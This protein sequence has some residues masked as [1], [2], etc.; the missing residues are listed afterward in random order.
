MIRESPYTVGELRRALE[1]FDDDD[2]ALVPGTDV[3]EW[4]PIFT[5][6]SEVVDFPEGE[7]GANEL[8]RRR[9]KKD[10]AAKRCV[11]LDRQ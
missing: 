6:R 2:I 11:V 1:K 8:Q 7:D 10:I 9:L 5:V 4:Q 3:Y